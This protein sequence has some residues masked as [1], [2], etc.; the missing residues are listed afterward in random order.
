MPDVELRELR[1][2][3][4]TWIHEACQDSEIQRWTLVPR[5]YTRA[6]AEWFVDNDPEWLSRVVVAAESGEPLGMIGV[7]DV[8]DGVANI[9][10]W[11]APWGRGRGAASAAVKHIVELVGSMTRLNAVTARV[12]E[13]NLASRTTVERA[14]FAESARECGACPDGE[15]LSDAVVYRLDIPQGPPAMRTAL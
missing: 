4:V 2:D 13:G 1:P 12:A 9:G 6:D 15:N 11:I 3:D 7:H 8:V 14:G 5:P 10:Y